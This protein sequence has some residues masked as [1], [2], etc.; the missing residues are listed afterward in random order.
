MTRKDYRLIAAALKEAREEMADSPDSLRGIDRA[1]LRLARALEIEGGLDI[2]GNRRFK[3][4]V[5]LAAAGIT[6]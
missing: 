4:D 3:M 6:A 1:T 5:F 2:N